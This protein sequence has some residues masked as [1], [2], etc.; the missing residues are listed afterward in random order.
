MESYSSS[1][2]QEVHHP[3]TEEMLQD[4]VAQLCDVVEQQKELITKLTQ[5]LSLSTSPSPTLVTKAPSPLPAFVVKP[6]D[7]PELTLEDLE[8]MEAGGKL[9]M[10]ID[11]VE[12]VTPDDGARYQV[13]KTRLNSKIALLIQNHQSKGRCQTWIELKKFLLSEFASEMT[14][15]Q[16]WK[17]IEAMQYEWETSP[18]SFNHHFRCKYA[19]LETNFPSEK[20]P[21]KDQIIKRKIC[22]GLPLQTKNKLE[23]FLEET[24]PLKKFIE[25]VEYE[26][27]FLLE[28]PGC[29]LFHVKSKPT[30]PQNN[31]STK[32]PPTHANDQVTHSQ[33]INP[34]MWE[35]KELARRVDEL[36]KQRTRRPWCHHCRK[37]NHSTQ[38]C[39][40][41]PR[42]RT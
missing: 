3:M 17:E 20:F 24:Y 1:V 39:W 23:A 18:H 7:I 31:N 38:D 22:Q 36:V 13:A 5:Q 40:G 15:D 28:A 12:Q 29:D 8:G 30:P 19:L 27:Q 25:R 37:D 16:A 2:K 32:T 33:P 35:V 26:R 6:R 9:A 34:L 11:R 41:R 10:F 21:N 14:V 4:Q 42:N